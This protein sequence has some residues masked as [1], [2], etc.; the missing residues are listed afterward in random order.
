MQERIYSQFYRCIVYERRLAAMPENSALVL[1]MQMRLEKAR[2]R[3]AA[4]RKR[5]AGIRPDATNRQIAELIGI[6]KGT[7]DC[8]LH[9]LKARWKNDPDKAILN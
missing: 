9:A 1:K 2:L 5:F 6:S 3:L 4:M 8:S 7:V